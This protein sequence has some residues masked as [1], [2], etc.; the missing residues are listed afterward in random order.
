MAVMRREAPPF[1]GALLLLAVPAWLLR[2]RG[3]GWTPWEGWILAAAVAPVAGAVLSTT[4]LAGSIAAAVVGAGLAALSG[5]GA[6]GGASVACVAAWLGLWT[7]GCH[8]L[9]RGAGPRRG[10]VCACALWGS[11]ILP[12]PWGRALDGMQRDAPGAFRMTRWVLAVSAPVQI[13]RVVGGDPIH[14][15][16]LYRLGYGDYLLGRPPGA[17]WLPSILL[18]A[19][20][21]CALAVRRRLPDAPAA[22]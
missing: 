16:W 3:V 2:L 18:A 15:P 13:D 1:C 21:V 9:L 11:M 4:G 8:L 19:G 7:A 10:A 6:A 14:R 20:G 22:P 5:A 12:V 17:W